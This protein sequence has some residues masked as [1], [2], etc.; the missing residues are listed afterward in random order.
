VIAVPDHGKLS[1]GIKPPKG[2]GHFPKEITGVREVSRANLDAKMEQ[3]MVP[4]IKVLPTIIPT[5]PRLQAKPIELKPDQATAEQTVVPEPVSDQLSDM[6]MSDSETEKDAQ[7]LEESKEPDPPAAPEPKAPKSR[8]HLT[9]RKIHKHARSTSEL[10]KHKRAKEDHSRA[11]DREEKKKKKKRKRSKDLERKKV[12][13]RKRHKHK[14]DSSKDGGL[15]K[16]S[17]MKL[18]NGTAPDQ[19][20]LCI[21]G[22]REDATED[23]IYKEIESVEGLRDTKIYTGK[24]CR[25]VLCDFESK[26]TM[27]AFWRSAHC[28]KHGI[29]KFGFQVEVFEDPFGLISTKVFT[30][31]NNRIRNSTEFKCS[32][33]AYIPSDPLLC[34]THSK[35]FESTEESKVEESV[36]E[37]KSE[38]TAKESKSEE[39]AK[40]TKPEEI[41]KEGTSESRKEKGNAE[42]GSNPSELSDSA[43]AEDPNSKKQEAED[44][45]SKNELKEADDSDNKM[46]VQEVKIEIPMHMFE[47]K[48]PEEELKRKEPTP[49]PVVDKV[50]IP[51]GSAAKLPANSPNSSDSMDAEK[52]DDTSESKNEP[53]QPKAQK[54]QSSKKEDKP[55]K[56]DIPEIK[57]KRKHAS[58]RKTSLS[59]KKRKS[60]SK[61]GKRGRGRPRKK[62]KTSTSPRIQVPEMSETNSSFPLELV[63]DVGKA[64]K[65]SNTTSTQ[66][67]DDIVASLKQSLMSF[68]TSNVS[69]APKEEA[70]KK[71]AK[72]KPLLPR[73]KRKPPASQI[74]KPKS[75]PEISSKPPESM[76]RKQASDPGP[77]RKRKKLNDSDVSTSPTQTPRQ[78]EAARI[79]LDSS[80]SEGDQ[81]AA[82]E[83]KDPIVLKKLA[84]SGFQRSVYTKIQQ[85]FPRRILS[86]E[87][88]ST[89]TDE[90]FRQCDLNDG[91]IAILRALTAE[92]VIDPIQEIPKM[93]MPSSKPRKHENGCLRCE[94]YNR[95]TNNGARHWASK[96]SKK[97]AQ[98][99]NMEDLCIFSYMPD[100][101]F[102]SSR[103]AYKSVN[104][105]AQNYS[106]FHNGDFLK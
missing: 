105:V 9:A 98:H 18:R 24:S 19:F 45:N 27:R 31:L 15:G 91:Q 90:E 62:P 41:E 86:W 93:Q 30:L 69:A 39:T 72:S 12:K 96:V 85:T 50:E 58:K 104:Q 103:F 28:G 71:P 29:D 97:N 80:D 7:L 59:K 101:F 74:I 5:D 78:L 84:D 92:H 21:D 2:D 82:A 46:E 55:K 63:K 38:E 95:R 70:P 6:D 26:E 81:S 40:E 14:E 3:V 87:D 75:K 43:V 49:E 56:L 100:S 67:S 1:P 88:F 61:V 99:G 23:A 54:K 77:Q 68:S 42:E 89:V 52:T 13:E 4:E 25:F 106:Y 102:F 48:P 8:N 16:S 35:F 60:D 76:K 33:T 53:R 36:N 57:K 22:I 47:F 64:F 83:K 65:V 44:P 17:G 11:K 10:K 94:P 73:R 51:V 37:S 79:A 66:Q 34:M 32:T 20:C